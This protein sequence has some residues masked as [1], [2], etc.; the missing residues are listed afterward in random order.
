MSDQQDNSIIKALKDFFSGKKSDEG[1]KIFN[2]W[3]QSHDDSVGY[4]S[5]LDDDKREEHKN[6]VFQSIK[7]DL[8]K[9]SSVLPTHDREKRT[10]K[11]PAIYRVAAIL[12]IGALLSVAGIYL[13]IVTETEK[14]VF[15]TIEMSNQV[16][17]ISAFTLPDG[18]NVWLSAASSIQYPEEFSDQNRTVILDGEAFFEVEQDA[19]RPFVVKSGPL[20]TTVLGTSFNVKAYKNDPGIEVTLATGSVEVAVE[21][22]DQKRILQPDQKVQYQ[23]DT[24]LSDVIETNAL[25]ARAWT[26][27]ELVFMRENFAAIARTFERWHGVKFEFEDESLKEETFVYHFRDMSLQNSMDVLSELADF[28]YEIDNGRVIIRSPSGL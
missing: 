21:G 7:E 11:W 3:F 26:Q 18:S 14:T 22:S 4:L 28:E 19:G 17:Q 25:L 15:A 8:D 23:A 10:E 9:E 1:E 20:T 6:R 27:Q 16:G 2:Q 13:S 5:R 24:G 12:I